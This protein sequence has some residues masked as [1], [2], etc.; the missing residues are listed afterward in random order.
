M[1]IVGVPAAPLLSL[2]TSLLYKQNLLY[3]CI[4]HSR[5][6]TREEHHI[7]VCFALQSRPFCFNTLRRLL[8]ACFKTLLENSKKHPNT[9][10][11]GPRVPGEREEGI[12]RQGKLREM[13]N[14]NLKPTVNK[15]QNQLGAEVKKAGGGT[16]MLNGHLSSLF[17]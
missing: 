2:G 8:E 6:S 16:A 3:I 14:I 7:T 5:G 12:K 13:W 10:V 17:I 9:F 11:I 4:Q 15:T 1:Q